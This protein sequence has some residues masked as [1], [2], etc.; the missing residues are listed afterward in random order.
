MMYQL[1]D[2]VSPESPVL[3]RLFLALFRAT[4]VPEFRKLA[5]QAGLTEDVVDRVLEF[6]ATF[7]GNMGNYLSFGDTKI[8]P[9][10]SKEEFVKAVEAGA[11]GDA[12]D[13]ILAGLAEVKDAVFALGETQRSLGW[14]E[15]GVTG[16]FGPGVNRS[17]I[18]DVNALMTRIDM[19]PYNTRLFKEDDGTLV[20]RVASG[21]KKEDPTVHEANGKKVKIVY[22][23]YDGRMGV[24]ADWLAKARDYAADDT[25]RAMLDAYVKH[26]RGGDI[27]DHK[28]AQ[29]Q[30][31]RDKGPV[32][33]TNIGFIE[34]YR[35]CSG[36]RGE[37]EGFVAVVNKAQSAKFNALVE[38]AP[39]FL[40]RLP[41]PATFEKDEF[42]APDFTSLEVLTFAG[43]GIPLG[44]NIPNYDDIRQTE[45]FKNVSLGN[46]LNAK[47]GKDEKVPFIADDD[48][49]MFIELRTEAF[50]V[51]VGGHELLGHGSGKLLIEDADGK[52]NFDEAKTTNPLDGGKITK[53]YKPGQTYDSVFGAMASSF[54]ECRAEC[55]GVVLSADPQMLKIFGFEGDKADDI[56]YTNWL[57]MAH[58]GIRALEFYL[59]EQKKWR[60]AHMQARFG[61][62]QAMLRAG[63][64]FVKVDTSVA[65]NITLHLDRT[66]IRSVGVP[67]VNDLLQK[68]QVFKATADLESAQKLYADFT[69]VNAEWEKLRP[70]VLA[71]KKPRRNFVQAHTSIGDD[72]K[73]KLQVFDASPAGMIES[74]LARF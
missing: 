69:D 31:I 66:K 74:M 21:D 33:E 10:C 32:V 15:Q 51:Q 12:R 47:S 46:V 35:D 37:F 22:G 40:E 64:D 26:F 68:I 73:A 58:A 11:R 41:W 70:I 60:Q 38:N 50:E 67:A 7:F 42:K 14:P 27:N 24:V 6:V 39:S 63:Q 5:V 20:I 56:L 49:K 55:V 45:G 44:I 17:D 57:L 54:E 29:R 4:P 59:P 3:F 25:Q 48:Q 1:I 9:R 19:S 2:K 18:E 65:D 52:L 28:E 16:Y 72:G 36:V 53:W 34:S 8:V 23:D 71:H 13:A 61:I 43:S 30:W 62:L